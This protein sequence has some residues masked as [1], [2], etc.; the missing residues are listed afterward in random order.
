MDLSPPYSVS[1]GFSGLPWFSFSNTSLCLHVPIG[2]GLSV[3]ECVCLS[4][5]A[6]VAVYQGVEAGVENSQP[7][8]ELTVFAKWQSGFAEFG[9]VS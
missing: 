2:P 5:K 8:R 1:G 6:A 3:A 9:L 7:F 4:L